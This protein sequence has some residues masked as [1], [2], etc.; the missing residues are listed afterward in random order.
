[1]E[2]CGRF[3]GSA[4]GFAGFKNAVFGATNIFFRFRSASC[5]DRVA[6]E[7]YFPIN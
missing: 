5:F 6:N 1:M 3:D 4:I 2:N 7:A